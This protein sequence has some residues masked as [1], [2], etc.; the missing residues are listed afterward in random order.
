MS[1]VDALL[2]QINEEVDRLPVAAVKQLGPILMEARQELQADL[3]KWFAKHPGGGDRFTPHQ[4]RTMLAQIEG[5][6]DHL[7]QT[8]A[9]VAHALN[10]AGIKAGD[11]AAAHLTKTISELGPVFGSSL[12]PIPI[13]P[14]GVMLSKSPLMAHHANSAARY[15]K[16]MRDDIM[17]QM[18]LGMIRGET[19]DQLTNRLQRLGGPKGLVYTRG[20][21]G[22][23]GARAEIISEGLF[24]RYRHWGERLV[25][26]EVIQAYNVLASEGIREAQEWEPGIKQRWDA[27]ADA[28]L[29]LR[30]RA[31]DHVVVDVGAP[32]PGGVMHPPLH[33]NC[34]C[35]VVVWHEEWTEDA[36]DNVATKAK[37][38]DASAL[39]TSITHPMTVPVA[40]KPP[41]V[42]LPKAPKAPKVTQPTM[43]SINGTPVAITSLEVVG[44]AGKVTFTDPKTGQVTTDYIN[45]KYLVLNKKDA[46]AFKAQEQADKAKK[47]AALA[48][49]PEEY[50]KGVLLLDGATLYPVKVLGIF[51]NGNAEVLAKG[52][53]SS[54]VPTSQLVTQKTKA[55]AKATKLEAKA[56]KAQALAAKKAA[57]TAKK[58]LVEAAKSG[59]MAARYQLRQLKHEAKQAKKFKQASAPRP[60]ETSVSA[61]AIA[62]GAVSPHGVV[63]PSDGDGIENQAIRVTKIVGFRNDVY[64]EVDFKVTEHNHDQVGRAIKQTARD[65]AKDKENYADEGEYSYRR[66]KVTNGVL[67]DSDDKDV[68]IREVASDAGD[69]FKTWK[70]RVPLP[71]GG[72]YEVELGREGANRNKVRIRVPGGD[73]V[74]TEEAIRDFGHKTGIGITSPPSDADRELMARAKIAAKINPKKWVTDDIGLS[75]PKN[76]AD[77]EARADKILKGKYEAMAKAAV[78][79]EVYP[80]H[81]VLVS[82]PMADMLKTEGKIKGVYHDTGAPGDALAAMLAPDGTGL[83]SS[84]E[85]FR[86]GVFI[87]GKSTGR[88]FETGGADGVF[89]RVAK[90]DT[91]METSR[92][93]YRILVDSDQLGRT[94]WWA[95]DHDNFGRA[96]A[97]DARSRWSL[98][99]MTKDEHV[100]GDNEVMFPKGVPPSAI[101][102]VVAQ[103]EDARNDLLA[104]F[105][106][107]NLT[108]I[109]GIPVEDFVKVRKGGY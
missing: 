108:E 17:R 63:M 10:M 9:D 23:P 109:N 21:A 12:N 78:E 27:A 43:A 20:K 18:A 19:I 96:E 67:M 104:G 85:R 4:Y 101:R 64:H 42:K 92:G 31:L 46:K 24:T 44:G 91:A 51:P 16:G 105:K 58:Q 74:K 102:G 49:I 95:F 79:K 107:R 54:I 70:T 32:F 50:K 59:D 6:L 38:F 60:L 71:D 66:R 7:G 3:A 72:H 34:R 36:K 47:K 11:L 69:R 76:R 93:R 61:D 30:C 2:T 81:R 8:R 103:S 48:A 14:A 45:K 52:K 15:T 57:Q 37:G 99:K 80:G 77:I 33:P 5:A 82:Q 55:E 65:A 90:T 75:P 13:R 39:P 98:D 73:P 53:F 86:R 100:S 25:R 26:T 56:Q 35:A 29:C 83:M 28:R 68:K 22:D 84:E 41:V 106:K 1:V 88:D 89:T 87:T 62:R 40:P 94:D 97:S